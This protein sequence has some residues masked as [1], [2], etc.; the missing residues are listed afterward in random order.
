MYPARPSSFVRV[1]VLLFGLFGTGLRSHAQ[2]PNN[3]PPHWYWQNPLPQGFDLLDL[4]VF[5]DSTALAV[6]NGGTVVKTTDYGRS[7]QVG[8]AG[9]IAPLT[10]VSFGSGL[11]G[12]AGHFNQPAA[13]RKTLDGGSTW[14]LQPLGL[15]DAATIND[16]QCLGPL[17]AYVLYRV[18]VTGS[19]ELRHTVDGGQTWTLQSRLISGDPVTMQFV[20]S[21]VGYVTGG[22]FGLLLLQKTTDGG[23]TWQRV[24]PDATQPQGYNSLAFVT[25]THGW[26][27]RSGN[28]IYRTRNGGLTW[29]AQ[30]LPSTAGRVVFADTLHGLCVGPVLYS[31]SNGGQTWTTTLAPDIY[32]LTDVRLQASGAGWMVGQ[33]GEWWR[34]RDYGAHWLRADSIPAGAAQQAQFPD[35]THVWVIKNRT[36]LAH[37]A[38]RGSTWQSVDLSTKTGTGPVDWNQ[39]FVQAQSFV[40]RDTGFVAVLDY[41][42]GGIPRLFSL[43]TQNGGQTWTL[44]QQPAI[45]TTNA[46]IPFPLVQ[47]MKFQSARRGLLVGGQGLLRRTTDGGLTWTSPVVPPTVSRRRTL[48]AIA[49]VNAQTVYVVGDSLTLLKS[50]DGGASFQAMPGLAAFKAGLPQPRTWNIISNITFA[51]P[52]VG[53]IGF[54]DEVVRTTDG[55][56]TWAFVA[57]PPDQ[58][59][60]RNN[61]LGFSFANAL[62]GW[63]LSY[64]NVAATTD[65]GQTWTRTAIFSPPSYAVNNSGVRIDRYN[66]WVNSDFGNLLHYSEKF[67]TTAPLAQTTFCTGDIMN[68][69]FQREGSFDLTEQAVRIELSNARGRFRPGETQLLGQGT[70]SPVQ[71]TV[72]AGL[73]TSGLYRVR[74]VRD[75]LS[76][77]GGDNGQDLRLIATPLAP[78]LAALPGQVLQATL[79]TASPVATRYE[80]E[81]GGVAVAG[82][83]GAQLTPRTSGA[84]RVRA[85]SATCCGPWSAPSTVVLATVARAAQE[86]RLYPNPAR[87]TLW[88]EQP[89]G[90]AAA[91]VQLLDVTGRVVW[92]GTA[93][94]GTYALPVQE[95]PAG[96]YLVRLQT[97]TGPPQV[98]RVVVEH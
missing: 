86:L 79:P 51:T 30:Q 73:S 80:W 81:V 63:A 20:S 70:S 24:T 29:Q 87:T 8:T 50:I 64:D 34:T 16:I 41:G 44:A 55:G 71:V 27:G 77:L 85:C 59:V 48:R 96:L 18:G 42:P 62:E 89:A 57:L 72:P 36:T 47:V 92:H 37:S 52:Q 93:G 19:T 9:T 67:L 14:T 45:A 35:P 46:S 61:F 65:G 28:K 21:T 69:S 10:A 68:V 4:H 53:L 13:V 33:R 38:D 84:Y 2:T 12:W 25:P 74:V 56:Q 97:M 66:G 60:V 6:G 82:A 11:V 83:S 54:G 5:N 95:V 40:D 32:T 23:L 49:W 78:Q 1:L 76:V 7:W 43:A 75:D 98:V 22:Y 15:A 17:E 3:L 91:A 31:T 39:G 88:L 58:S 90:A 94:A 26:V